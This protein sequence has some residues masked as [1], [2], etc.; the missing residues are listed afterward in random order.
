MAPVDL[1]C[2]E[3]LEIQVTVRQAEITAMP[4]SGSPDSDAM[5]RADRE[6]RNLWEEIEAITEGVQ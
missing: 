1:E 4:R 6:R 5:A 3:A 2:L